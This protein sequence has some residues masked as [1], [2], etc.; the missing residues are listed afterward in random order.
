MTIER[1]ETSAELAE[2]LAVRRRHRL[3]GYHLN[4][5]DLEEHA[6]IETRMREGGYQDRQVYEL[7][8]NGADAIGVGNEG[9]IEL[10]LS[11]GVLY[12]ANTG[13]PLNRD[14]IIALLQSHLSPKRQDQI[15]RF[16]LGFKSMLGISTKQ[17]IYSQQNSILFDAEKARKEFEARSLST[18]DN[19]LPSLRLAWPVSTDIRHAVSPVL[20]ELSQWATTIVR[21]AVPDEAS[22]AKVS[23]ALKQFPSEFLLF[24][25]ATID[26][27]LRDEDAGWSREIH[28]EPEGEMVA[29]NVTTDGEA[30]STRWRCFEKVIDLPDGPAKV[31]AGQLHDRD[32][33]PLIWAVPADRTP[34]PGSFWAF[35]PLEASCKV[36][37]IFNA[38][39]KIND[40]RTGLLPGAYNELLADTFADM[41]VENLAA[42]QRED[43]PGSI[44]DYLPRRD[45]GDKL[46]GRIAEKIW[47]FAANQSLVPDAT[48]A[49]RPAKELLDHPLIDQ[50]LLTTWCG[51]APEEHQRNYVHPTVMASPGRR[52]RLQQLRAAAGYVPQPAVMLI[53]AKRYQ[54]W[55]EAV[56]SSNV[57]TAAKVLVFA[58]EVY[59]STTDASVWA[60]I[61]Q[62]KLVLGHDEG[63]HAVTSPGLYRHPAAPMSAPP[64]V[65]FVHADVQAGTGVDA[66]L[67]TLGVTELESNNWAKALLREMPTSTGPKAQA[68]WKAWWAGLHDSPPHIVSAFFALMKKSRRGLSVQSLEGSFW[69]LKETLEPGEV[70]SEE[71]ASAEGNR[72]FFIDLG[73]HQQEM[74]GLRSLGLAEGPC[75]VT[76]PNWG[77]LHGT[78]YFTTH[79]VSY[80][81]DAKRRWWSERSE[82]VRQWENSGKKGPEPGNPYESYIVVQSSTEFFEPLAS[83]VHGSDHLRANITTHVMEIH[84]DTAHPRAKVG[85]KT[86]PEKYAKCDY[87]GPLPW[88]LFHHGALAVEDSVVEVADLAYMLDPENHWKDRAVASII[89]LTEQ[90]QLWMNRLIE[91]LRPLGWV[92]LY[93]KH[94]ISESFWDEATAWVRA[95]DIDEKK[96]RDFYRRIIGTDRMRGD[97]LLCGQEVPISK[98]LV[99]SQRSLEKQSIELGVPVLW[100]D[101]GDISRAEQAGAKRLEDDV[102]LLVDEPSHPAPILA[103]FPEVE[104]VLGEQERL[105][106]VLYSTC[107][108]LSLELRAGETRWSIPQEFAIEGGVVYAKRSH[109]A[110][111]ATHLDAL[112]RWLRSKKLIELS[113]DELQQANAGAVIHRRT[114]VAVQPT[115]AL[116]LL[117]AVGGMPQPLLDLLVGP[118]RHE[119]E[120]REVDA[121]QVAEL[122][123]AT[124]G[125]H[126]LRE[127]REV[128][129]AQGLQPPHRW[130]GSGTAL[131]FVRDIGFPDEFA[132]SSSG[133]RDDW[134]TV[135]GPTR[136]P[137]LHDFQQALQS[138]LQQVLEGKHDRP[139]AVLSLPTGAGKT[140]VTVQ[141]LVNFVLSKDGSPLVLWLAQQDELCE[142][143]VRSFQ[144]VWAAEG[145]EG[146]ELRVS[147]LWGGI[148]SRISGLE[149]G[150]QVVVATIQTLN[151]RFDYH[152]LSWLSRPD[153][154]VI[155][156]AHRGITRSYTSLLRW[157]DELRPAAKQTQ[158]NESIPIL[159]LSATPFR[160]FD[161]DETERLANRFGG[162][163]IPGPSEQLSIHMKLQNIGVLARVQHELLRSE[164]LFEFSLAEI[165]EIRRFSLGRFPESASRRLG[166]DKT[167]NKLIIDRILKL[168]DASQV[169]VFANS[170][171]HAHLLAGL[172]NLEGRRSAAISGDTRFGLRQQFIE[173]FKAGEIKV[174]TNYGVL[175]TGF[176]AP[177]VDVLMI[178]RPTFSPGLYQQM[179]GRGLRG[180]KN[181]GKERCLLITVLDNLV[182]YGD[183]LA[184]HHFLRYFEGEEAPSSSAPTG[185]E[186]R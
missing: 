148:G 20:D 86:S 89:P 33:I 7:V 31:D 124:H 88:T 50:D 96:R 185:G 123:L 172:L 168:P 51:L 90:Q 103:T 55:L 8:Q 13:E 161:D 174:L 52:R 54:L 16:G 28:V 68:A 111:R 99:T 47:E 48:G 82:A 66:A 57:G 114:Q 30:S 162:R 142:Q 130:T 115:L 147:R 182:R 134:E 22:L 17:V 171:E 19:A 2:W 59:E 10:V 12:C 45:G 71:L 119:V 56:T 160:G 166:E 153:A 93:H 34:G 94:L 186:H 170:V 169:L 62:A 70:V 44:L 121:I 155:D 102:R 42:L 97:F 40:D 1:F 77:R 14:G 23:S 151:N 46:S 25:G 37:G 120:E 144:Q 165:E 29:V 139:R 83:L 133:R 132:G 116:R 4:T 43:D 141:A 152:S 183:Q 118:L 24:S 157:L 65:V 91:G 98:V 64:G 3:E 53:L 69:P 180:K 15:G 150:P 35:F 84:G 80:L 126:A 85:H 179:V 125:P 127:L 112:L 108:S 159:G 137:E 104:A 158:Y 39:W 11:E 181:G 117:H 76:L 163:L 58:A 176:D 173:G 61:K 78:N 100:M 81:W 131:A 36:P 136:L 145:R 164:D 177:K 156:E 92:H 26:L 38:P 79:F 101:E 9:R 143:A 105:G 67:E 110:D 72:R 107:G 75:P 149:S 154:V 73:F 175:T 109:Q 106:E 32:R 60:E 41:V 167:R 184:F 27:V 138:D 129:D 135:P 74:E 95:P 140:R 178:A 18:K 113:Y 128:L 87:P 6:N 122:V 49:L 5:E 146:V 63:L 21:A